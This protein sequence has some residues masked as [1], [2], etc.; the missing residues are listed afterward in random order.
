[1]DTSTEATNPPIEVGR[2][3]KGSHTTDMRRC[4][5]CFAEQPQ[6]EFRKRSTQGDQRFGQCR[7]CHNAAERSR[8]QIA[9]QRLNRRALGQRLSQIRRESS[10]TR[11]AALC[12]EM[13]RECGGVAGFLRQWQHCLELDLTHGGYRAFRHFDSIFRLVQFCDRTPPDYSRM[14][15]SELE[16]AIENITRF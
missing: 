4:E 13:L 2:T 9:R 15:D 6:T 10:T 7:T 14:S 16:E 5:Q 3:E 11:V 1:M 12:E 8:R